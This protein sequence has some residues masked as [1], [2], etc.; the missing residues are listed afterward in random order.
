MA[1]AA[2][3]SLT[4]GII[5]GT[6]SPPLS[7]E[8][9]IAALAA[10]GTG[11]MLIPDGK[12]GGTGMID[13]ATGQYNDFAPAPTPPPDLLTQY[14][15]AQINAGAI[16]ASQFHAVTLATLNAQLSTHKLN[17]VSVSATPSS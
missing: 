11:H 13:L 7:N 6:I 10:E 14:V 2:F 5:S 8:A 16:D 1:T 3:Y 12:N 4:T 9:Q 15:A 17:T